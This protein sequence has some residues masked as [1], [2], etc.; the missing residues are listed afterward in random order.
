MAINLSLAA[1][2]SCTICKPQLPHPPRPVVTASETSK[3]IIIGQAPGRR[4]HD[5]GIPWND[6][7]G[8]LLRSWMGIGKETFYNTEMIALMPMGFCYPGKGKSGDMPP[9]PECAPRWHAELLEQMPERKLIVLIGQ[10]SQAYYLG[11]L[12]QKS[13]A[14][15][16]KRHTDYL[17]DFFPLPHPSP[18]NR[19]WL[20]NNSWFDRDVL[21]AFRATV[22]HLL[23]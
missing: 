2:K 8:D 17:P 3:I 6:P 11:K 12:R 21:P 23:R 16:V 14:E 5:T 7:S 13:L 20:K 1:I 4:V 10:Y 9:R 15:T 19:L 22:N 18:R